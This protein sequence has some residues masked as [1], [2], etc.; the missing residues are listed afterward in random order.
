MIMNL[1]NLLV[2]CNKLWA[3]LPYL[4]FVVVGNWVT[5]AGGG[6]TT[7]HVENAHHV[8]KAAWILAVGECLIKC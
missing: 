3:R 2:M 1:I 7:L 6:E 4:N 5:M 8:Y